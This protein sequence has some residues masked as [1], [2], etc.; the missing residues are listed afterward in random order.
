MSWTPHATVATIVEKEGRFLCVEE[1]ASGSK[2]INQPAGHVDEGETIE[3]A[4]VRETFEETGWHVTPEYISGFYTY[5]AEEN[6]VTYHRFCF[7]AKAES[8]DP[9]SPLDEGIIAAHWFT[10]EE[11]EARADQ[12]RSPMVLKCIDDYLAGKHY[13]LELITEFNND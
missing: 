7:V 5:Y 12:L 11:L 8:F 10:R 13:P 3:A 6:G 9:S 4:A 1:L 2:V